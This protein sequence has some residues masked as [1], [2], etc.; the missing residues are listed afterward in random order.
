M[1][2]PGGSAGEVPGVAAGEGMAAGGIVSGRSRLVGEAAECHKG[3]GGGEIGCLITLPT[4][5]GGGDR[6][7]GL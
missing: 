7:L 6:I 5:V 3:S 1:G 2:L 4:L